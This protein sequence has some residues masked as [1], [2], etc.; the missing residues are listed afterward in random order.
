MNKVAKGTGSAGVLSALWPLMA[1][2]GDSYRA[3]PEE[4]TDI[5]A[6]TKGKVKVGDVIN[7]D[8]IELVQDLI[9]PMLY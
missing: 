8:N 4:L 9:D 1:H 7:K 5:E 2:T 6:Y 3:Y